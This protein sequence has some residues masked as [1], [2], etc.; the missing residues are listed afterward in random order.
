[1]T[2]SDKPHVIR[3]RGPWKCARDRFAVQSPE[4]ECSVAD[5][6][7]IRLPIPTDDLVPPGYRGT[8]ELRRN[9]NWPESLG[10]RESLWLVVPSAAWPRF[11]V[12]LNGVALDAVE[13][14]RTL[15]AAWE[16]TTRITPHNEVRLAWEIGTQASDAGTSWFEVLENLSWVDV[17]LEVRLD[18][19]PSD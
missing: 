9:F 5:V 7:E 16:I 11:S 6:F 10:Y 18:V 4:Y 13:E 14:P 19:G 12:E 3:L 8:L 15:P 17:H 1:M 2:P